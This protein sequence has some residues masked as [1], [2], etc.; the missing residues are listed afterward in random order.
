MV[1]GLKESRLEV[2]GDGEQAD[3]DVRQR[4]VRNEVV[5][6]RLKIRKIFVKNIF[7]CFVSLGAFFSD[8]TVRIDQTKG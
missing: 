8:P 7:Y 1:P 2:E 3:D 5:G 4:Q 6:H